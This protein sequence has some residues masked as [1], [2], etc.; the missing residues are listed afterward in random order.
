M[1][2]ERYAYE[3]RPEC[4]CDIQSSEGA[5]GLEEIVQLVKGLS[6]KHKNLSSAPCIHAKDLHYH[7]GEGVEGRS[8]EVAGEPL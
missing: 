2:T 3:G 4:E 8:L 5:L 6:G 7:A 1:K